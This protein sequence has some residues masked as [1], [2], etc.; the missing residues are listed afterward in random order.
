MKKIKSI[1]TG[2]LLGGICS[3]TLLSAGEDKVMTKTSD[4]EHKVN[5]TTLCEAKG[6]RGSTP[7]E[8]YIKNDKVVKVVTLPNQESPNYFEKVKK[9]LFPLFEGVKISEGK[10][11]AESMPPDGCTGATYS[12]RAAQKNIQAA[13]QYYE[14]HK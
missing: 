3:V 12:T 10:R 11:I 9:Y 7:L 6:F 8:V 13:L 5:T 14:T 2:L 4:G 1:V